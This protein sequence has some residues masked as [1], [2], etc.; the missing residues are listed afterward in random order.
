M[1]KKSK[2]STKFHLMSRLY[3]WYFDPS[4][5][6]IWF[7]CDFSNAQVNAP[8]MPFHNRPPLHKLSGFSGVIKA[9]KTSWHLTYDDTLSYFYIFL[10]N[11]EKIFKLIV[12][13]VIRNVNYQDRHNISKALIASKTRLKSFMAVLRSLCFRTDCHAFRRWWLITYLDDCSSQSLTYLSLAR[14]LYYLLTRET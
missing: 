9:L 4:L 13:L 6:A 3:I 10:L 7:P 2:W 5:P 14:G 12:E 1:S 8:E 11:S